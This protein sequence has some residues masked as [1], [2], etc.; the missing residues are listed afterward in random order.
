MEQ[1]FANLLLN[2]DWWINHKKLK[3]EYAFGGG[4]LG[5]DNISIIDRNQFHSDEGNKK[6]KRNINEVNIKQVDAAAW[7]AMFCLNLLNILVELGDDGKVHYQENVKRVFE[8]FLEIAHIF[9]EFP[10]KRETIK[11]MRAWISGILRITFITIY[12]TFVQARKAKA[13]LW[14]SL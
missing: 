13:L 10:Q 12:C 7:M 2:F 3:D 9:I 14:T 4:F 8:V 6:D 1:I 5:L 11:P